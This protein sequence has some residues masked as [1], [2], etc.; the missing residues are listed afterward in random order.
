MKKDLTAQGK[1]SY[2]VKNWQSYNKSLRQRGKIT[3]WIEESVL[4]QWREI[5]PKQKVVGEQLYPD[6]VIQYWVINMD[7][8]YVRQQVL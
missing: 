5:D 1:D 8:N 7:K 2:K 6:S 3:L 4:R